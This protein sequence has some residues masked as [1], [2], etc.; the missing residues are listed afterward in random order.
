VVLNTR[1]CWAVVAALLPAAPRNSAAVRVVP[2]GELTGRGAEVMD[3]SHHVTP[4]P[5]TRS[6]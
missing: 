5:G 6:H 4:G 2:R 3:A 1:R